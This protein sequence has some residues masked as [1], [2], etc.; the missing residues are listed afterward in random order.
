MHRVGADGIDHLTGIRAGQDQAG[1]CDVQGQP[2][3]GG[4]QQNRGKGRKLH[5]LRDIK[6]QQKN[7]EAEPEIDDDREVEDCRWNRREQDDQDEHRPEHQQKVFV[8]FEDFPKH[9]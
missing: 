7:G 6:R 1:R 2:E 4:Y 8:A 3:E 5:R 9:R